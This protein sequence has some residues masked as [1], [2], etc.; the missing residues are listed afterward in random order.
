MA[1]VENILTQF[2]CH[3]AG[4][5]QRYEGRDMKTLHKGMGITQAEFDAIAADLRASLDYY[6]IPRADRDE[7]LKIVGGTAR[8]IVK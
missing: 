8:D 1:H 5:P 6:K 3:A 4:G 2:I 7:L